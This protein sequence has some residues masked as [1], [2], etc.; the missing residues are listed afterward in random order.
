MSNRL[1]MANVHAIIGLL[2]QGWSYR[3]ISRELRVDRD[4]VAR[5]NRLWRGR[6]NAA[7]STPG[8]ANSSDPNAAIS[9][10]GSLLEDL[11]IIQA[12]GRPPG[13]ASQCDPF[14]DTVSKKLDN[15]LS[16]QRIWQLPEPRRHNPDYREKLPAQR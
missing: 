3:R 13:R 16:G 11:V 1:K 10:A 2:E 7:I 5:Y 8:S 15:G 6:S 12:S 4:T 9:T 14:K